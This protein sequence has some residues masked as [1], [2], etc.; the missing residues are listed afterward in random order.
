MLCAW[1]GLSQVMALEPTGGA[2]EVRSAVIERLLHVR[3]TLGK[4]E[5][6]LGR[7][8][9]WENSRLPGRSDTSLGASQPHLL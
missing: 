1:R 2:Y 8:S 6:P 3:L 7:R 4:A 5:G 9:L